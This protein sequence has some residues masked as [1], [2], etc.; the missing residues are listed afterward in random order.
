MQIADRPIGNRRLLVMAGIISSL[1]L[2]GGC[3]ATIR[4]KLPE[5]RASLSQTA[6]QAGGVGLAAVKDA[7]SGTSGGGIGAAGVEIQSDLGDYVHNSFASALAR[8]GLQVTDTKQTVAAPGVKQTVVVTVQSAS[9]ST[10][11]AILQPATV[12]V[13]LAVQ[14]YDPA[15]KVI[16]A[17]NYSGSTRETL[18]IHGQAGYDEN[19]G[20]LVA[21]AA[22]SAIEQALSDPKFQTA[23]NG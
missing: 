12:N 16:F 14:V 18:G 4:P 9:V 19:T 2:I 11:D 7:R 8:K 15:E 10:I 13:G 6:P 22:D 23:I 17:E 21:A 5:N 1:T 20:R 3:S